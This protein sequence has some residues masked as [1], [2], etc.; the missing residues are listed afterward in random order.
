MRARLDRWS[1]GSARA[2]V[3]DAPGDQSEANAEE[4]FG[5]PA[6][7]LELHEAL[8]TSHAV[9]IAS[10]NTNANV[11]PLLSN[12]LGWT[13]RVQAHRA[14]TVHLVFRHSPLIALPRSLE[15]QLGE[16]VLPTMLSIAADQ[17]FDESGV[18]QG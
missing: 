8:R 4:Q 3:R 15:L 7:V 9:L 14:R 12:A 2:I 6:P 11:S 10:P 17:A 5:I 18:L 1:R 13:S 16:S